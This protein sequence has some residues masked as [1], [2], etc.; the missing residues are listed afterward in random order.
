M[1]GPGTRHN[2]HT[3]LRHAPALHLARPRR[4]SS[5]VA[6]R[7]LAAGL[8][9]VL[10]VTLEQFVT[11]EDLSSEQDGAAVRRIEKRGTGEDTPRRGDECELSY[12][13]FNQRTGAVFGEKSTCVLT[14]GEIPQR[15]REAMRMLAEGAHVD[16]VRPCLRSRAVLHSR[17]RPLPP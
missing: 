6:C 11:F 15:Q 1:E 10:K 9:G 5:R 4:H 14:I 3:R 2:K 8:G 13:I 17:N 12:R 7:A 16:Q